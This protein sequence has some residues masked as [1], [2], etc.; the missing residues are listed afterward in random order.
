MQGEAMLAVSDFSRAEYGISAATATAML[1]Y[2]FVLLAITGGE[3]EVTA[4]QRD[5]LIRHQ[6]RF[7]APDDVLDAYLDFEHRDADLETLV[8]DIVTDVPTWSPGP[9][10]IY[11]AIQMC[12]VGGSFDI[13]AQRK[14]TRA[15]RRLGVTDDI[16]LTIRTLIDM[17]AAVGKMRRALFGIDTL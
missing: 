9:H 15:A 4:A 3:D 12:A 17:E 8:K 10:L 5:W 13:P 1:H 6:R 11:H 7:G 2:G 14:V 16:V